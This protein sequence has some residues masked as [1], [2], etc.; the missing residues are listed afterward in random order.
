MSTTGRSIATFQLREQFAVEGGQA[1]WAVQLGRRIVD[2][3]T[4]R[5]QPKLQW[6]RQCD[7]S[8]E[9]ETKKALNGNSK[10]NL[11]GILEVNAR[12]ETR[13]VQKEGLRCAAQPV[14]VKFQPIAQPASHVTPHIQPSVG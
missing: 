12:Q 11:Q 14:S 4:C 5:L 8:N 10:T 1:C 13:G 7:N 9:P 2:P 6:G 3:R